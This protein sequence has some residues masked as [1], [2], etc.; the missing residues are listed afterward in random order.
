MVSYVLALEELYLYIFL[1]VWTDL[2]FSLF[3]SVMGWSQSSQM[4]WGSGTPP[5]PP[6]PPPPSTRILFL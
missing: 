6:P 5:T 3:S 2:S 1:Q 4:L